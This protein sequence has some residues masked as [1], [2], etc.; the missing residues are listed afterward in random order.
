MSTYRQFNVYMALAMTGCAIIF[1]LAYQHKMIQCIHMDYLG[2][3][4]YTCGISRDFINF[5]NFQFETPI[6]EK[7]A[8]LFISFIVQ[9]IL[10]ISCFVVEGYHTLEKK[11]IRKD[12]LLSSIHFILILVYLNLWFFL[13]TSLYLWFH[14]REE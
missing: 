12:I 5:M 13:L 8:F 14:L 6:N 9:F 1:Y 11:W 10:R 7:S 4:C 3:P 2:Q